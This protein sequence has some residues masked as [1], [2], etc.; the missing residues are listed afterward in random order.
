MPTHLIEINLSGDKTLSEKFYKLVESFSNASPDSESV[1]GETDSVGITV[2]VTGE[3][4]RGI[5]VVRTHPLPLI[6]QIL[7]PHLPH[8]HRNPPKIS[9]T[10]ERG[11]YD[12]CRY[13]VQQLLIYISLHSSDQSNQSNKSNH[14]KEIDEDRDEG[15]DEDEDKIQKLQTLFNVISMQLSHEGKISG[16]R[17][18][19]IEGISGS[20]ISTSSEPS[21]IETGIPSPEK[22]MKMGME[23]GTVMRFKG[24]ECRVWSVWT[25][26]TAARERY[27]GCGKDGERGVGDNGNGD[28]DE[29]EGEEGES[30]AKRIDW[31]KM[32][33][34]GWEERNW[35]FM[36][37]GE[38]LERGKEKG[39]CVVM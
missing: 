17:Q 6:L 33:V 7:S 3:E 16:M 9:Q 24:Q 21:S 26:W 37:F 39:R 22:E 28:E 5:I 32:G 35:V 27:D 2:D 36:S 30:L 31:G 13:S 14:L 15:K 19:E 34:L 1:S 10:T 25:A 29:G 23:M 18:G 20:S 38:F 11:I 12:A 8:F 4:L